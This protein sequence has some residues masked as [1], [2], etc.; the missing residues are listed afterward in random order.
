MAEMRMESVQ[1][2]ARLNQAKEE[3]RKKGKNN[4]GKESVF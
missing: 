3:E 2:R 4:I 1:R